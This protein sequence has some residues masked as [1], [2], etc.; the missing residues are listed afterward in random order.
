M[1]TRRDLI[2]GGVVVFVAATTACSLTEG[3]DGF[4]GSKGSG[5]DSGGP[6]DV[7]L[8]GGD[9][10]VGGDDAAALDA[11][12]AGT[13]ELDAQDP[14]TAPVF[15]DGGSFCSSQD[16][17]VFCE[18]FDI[19]DL[20][21]KWLREGLFARLTNNAAR[22][23]PNDYFLDAP[24]ST[25]GGTFVSKITHSFGAPSTNLVVSFDF[26][27]EKVNLASSILMLAALE[28]TNAE[29]KYSLRLVYSSGSVRLEESNLVAPPDN[30]DA[31]HPFFA[32]PMDRW[33]RVKLDIV[34]SGSTPGVLVSLDDAPMG[35]RETIAPTIGMDP[36]PT[37]I[38]GAVYAANPHT[39]WTLRYDNVTVKYR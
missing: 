13:P 27:P 9:A 15:I 38:L 25:I 32:I 36:T 21:A 3:F 29:A 4:V 31:Y 19:T 14:N 33:S 11:G 18:D 6:P 16:D 1:K 30:K 23:A 10:S 39:G 5:I 24:A 2:R 26:E 28:Y 22:S 35:V 17:A 8:T 37:L 20:S 34:A 7:Q 12:D